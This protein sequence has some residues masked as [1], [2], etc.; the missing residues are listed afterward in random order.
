MFDIKRQITILLTGSTLFGAALG[1]CDED[2]AEYNAQSEVDEAQLTP[3]EMGFGDDWFPV[4]PGLWSRA[5]EHGEQE[6]MGIGEA[7]KLHAIASLESAQDD[8]KAAL[9]AEDREDT[10]FNLAELDALIDELRISSEPLAPEGVE[11]RCS[12][13]ISLGADA[14]PISCGVGAKAWASFSHCSYVGKVQTYTQSTCGYETKIHQCGPKSGTSVSCNSQITITGPS[15][16][17]SLAWA[18]VY[19]PT[20]RVYV[21]DENTQRG[22]CSPP[23]P[24]TFTPPNNCPPYATNCQIP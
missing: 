22:S 19:G 13:T 14:Y 23:P 9:A 6:F 8:L 11:P 17:K 15:P 4:E 12:A 24:T 16:C 18:E 7:G 20:G 2:A 3:A 5:N 21:W 1:G 10:R